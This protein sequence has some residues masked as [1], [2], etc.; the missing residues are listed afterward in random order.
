MTQSLQ[1]F[2][3]TSEMNTI[4]MGSDGIL[5]ELVFTCSK[6]ISDKIVSEAV[7]RGFPFQ[8]TDKGVNLYN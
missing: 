1:L 5:K 4:N 7:K 8:R 2:G 3:I 6:E